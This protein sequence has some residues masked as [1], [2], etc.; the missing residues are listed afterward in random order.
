MKVQGLSFGELNAWQRLFNSTSGHL[1]HE[2]NTNDD[3]LY[4]CMCNAVECE[5]G[6]N[7][8]HIVGI[9]LYMFNLRGIIP[10]EISDFQA[11]EYLILSNNALEGE[12]PDISNLNLWLLDLSSNNLT[13]S[14]PKSVFNM[15]TLEILRL[16]QNHLKGSIPTSVGSLKQ[17][18]S[19][20][21][22]ENDLSGTIPSELGQLTH[23]WKLDLSDNTFSG[24]IPPSL[25]N[26]MLLEELY[27]G[28]NQLKGAIPEEIVHL[29]QL[30][31]L[32]LSFNA[33]TGSI[34]PF[35]GNMSGLVVL[36]LSYNEFF[37]SFPQEWFDSI[38][39]PKAM[40]NSKAHRVSPYFTSLQHLQICCNRLTGELSDLMLPFL[41]VPTLNQLNLS[42]NHI[43]GNFSFSNWSGQWFEFTFGKQVVKSRGSIP[44][45]VFDISSN[46]IKGPL[47]ENLPL[48]LLVLFVNN[49]QLIGTIPDSFFQLFLFLTSGNEL[50]SDT[51]PEFLQITNEW[52]EQPSSSKESSNITCRTYRT[53]DGSVRQFEIAPSYDNFSRCACQSGHFGSIN[54]GVDCQPAPPGYFVSDRNQSLPQLCPPGSITSSSG[55]T[56]CVQ[57]PPNSFA[58]RYST[59]CSPCFN[60]GA[61]CSDGVIQ[62]EAGWWHPSNL[63]ISENVTQRDLY[64]CNNVKACQICQ[65]NVS[66]AKALGYDV[67][68]PLFSECVD[69]YYSSHRGKKTCKS[70]D[71]V[72]FSSRFML[73][74][75]AIAIIIFFCLPFITQ[76]SQLPSTQHFCHYSCPTGRIP[77]TS[78]VRV[79]LSHTQVLLMLSQLDL[80]PLWLFEAFVKNTI[81]AV[82]PD[83]SLLSVSCSNKKFDFVM[84]VRVSAFLPAILLLLY[85]LI[86]GVAAIVLK[87]PTG[88]ILQKNAW[89]FTFL[90][91]TTHPFVLEKLLYAIHFH[92]QPFNGLYYLQADMRINENSPVFH[93]IRGIAITFLVFYLLAPLVS[94]VIL[95]QK[96]TSQNGNKLKLQDF[97]EQFGFLY[98]GYR[99]VGLFY[100]WELVVFIRKLSF[101]IISV[102]LAHDPLLQLFSANMVIILS[103]IAHLTFRPHR[104]L[105][106][107]SLESKSIVVLAVSLLVGETL[108]HIDESPGSTG[109]FF[110]VVLILLNIWLFVCGIY[111][112]F[113]CFND[114]K[115]LTLNWKPFCK[116][117]EPPII[118]HALELEK[119]LY[120]FTRVYDLNTIDRDESGNPN[121]KDVVELISMCN[122]LVDTILDSS[123]SQVNTCDS[124]KVTQ[125][126][127]L[128]SQ[129]GELEKE[130]KIGVL[131]PF[132]FLACVCF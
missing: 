111:E 81:G 20:E 17:L 113:G 109:D 33:L 2:C 30:Q 52:A 76:Y 105:A 51:L 126:I 64:R 68:T 101:I 71:D 85:I 72:R 91:Y 40:K 118:L 106:V 59:R 107:F 70:C 11:L 13:G 28:I 100:L 7:D 123:L 94:A 65:T 6:G 12:I 38:S 34:P 15:T 57:C 130:K 74:T 84:N 116:N 45:V 47:P 8:E 63:V 103:L 50:Q 29:K 86:N 14:I 3:F 62:L 32:F 4:P 36:D 49:N 122:K 98:E 46:E 131:S 9:D 108:A 56:K 92:P 79:F 42:H 27:L 90:V 115:W 55:N 97:R 10:E 26:L 104:S 39:I 112:S 80:E 43:S 25:G 5:F 1:W 60:K 69:G 87:E 128:L 23:L 99:M 21:L 102:F 24:T 125:N 54:E 95:F 44:L 18:L 37:G 75:P 53:I 83:L 48:T 110:S 41:N 66:C 67:T 19:L 127:S 119:Q 61:K 132:S 35:L 93:S 31:W 73:I 82:F 121:G 16:Q 96:A 129:L 124:V 89:Y 117:I 120:K 78:V 88:R 22:G 58:S 114:F 77:L